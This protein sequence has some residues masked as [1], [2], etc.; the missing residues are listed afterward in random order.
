MKQILLNPT[1][2][3]KQCLNGLK[4]K[5]VKVNNFK[6]LNSG[7]AQLIKIAVVWEQKL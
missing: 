1:A 4:V 6:K 5:Q 3:E 7:E 2:L